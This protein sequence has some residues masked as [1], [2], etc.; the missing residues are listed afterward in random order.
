MKPVQRLGTY[1]V[2]DF[3]NP[4][5]SYVFLMWTLDQRR[6][7]PKF[8]NTSPL[9]EKAET[10]PETWMHLSIL[11]RTM[12]FQSSICCESLCICCE[13]LWQSA[14]WYYPVQSIRF[15]LADKSEMKTMY[16][17]NDEFSESLLHKGRVEEMP[18]IERWKSTA[19]VQQSKTKVTSRL[20]RPY[21]LFPVVTVI[22]VALFAVIPKPLLYNST[23]ANS[24]GSHMSSYKSSNN[25]ATSVMNLLASNEYGTFTAPYPWMTDVPGTQLVEPYK[26]T[27]L[28]LTG[29]AVDSG[30]YSFEWIIK[31]FNGEMKDGAATQSIIVTETRIYQITVNAYLKADASRSSEAAHSYSTRLVSK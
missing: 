29:T 7:S 22:V 12:Q 13:S 8:S 3:P 2:P 17:S 16:G 4:P 26:I 6:E 15:T 19:T 14:S 21:I 30:L 1:C 23:Q 20:L 28:T 10:K 9:T 5:N 25:A 18:D 24:L 31:D 27:N 11:V